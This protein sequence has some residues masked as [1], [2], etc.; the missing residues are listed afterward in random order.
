MTMAQSNSMGAKKRFYFSGV[1][2]CECVLSVLFVSP[3]VFRSCHFAPLP[4]RLF[5]FF[6]FF[7]RRHCCLMFFSRFLTCLC[8]SAPFIFSPYSLL[9]FSFMISPCSQLSLLSASLCLNESSP[10]I[11][12][13]FPLL[14]LL[15]FFFFLPPQLLSL[16]TCVFLSAY[17]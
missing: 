8:F 9:S 6:F 3:S 17:V 14:S 12:I 16:H 5:F 2:V 1:T 11:S 15:I 4:T 13:L 10:C 7:S